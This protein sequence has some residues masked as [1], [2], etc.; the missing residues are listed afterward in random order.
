MI[1]PLIILF[2]GILAAIGY[3]INYAAK[4]Y[5]KQQADRRS[6]TE[7]LGFTCDDAPDRT[8]MDCIMALHRRTPNQALSLKNV[9]MR[10]ESAYTVY[11]LDLIDSSGE[12]TSELMHGGVAIF[13]ESLVIPRFSLM[14]QIPGRGTLT[15]LVNLAMSKLIAGSGQVMRFKDHPAFD[16]RYFF[17]GSDEGALRSFF[18]KP[19]LD[20]LCEKPM[21][22]I[23]GMP[24]AFTY[25]RNTTPAFPPQKPLDQKEILQEA[26][27]LFR[28]F[29]ETGEKTGEAELEQ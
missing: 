12:S 11:I 9:F 29:Q 26:L 10:R 20:V 25:F 2:V 17:V 7:A 3:G 19:L 1:E 21:R 13:S 24:G 4:L 28:M 22:K 14:F 6:T 15:D 18:T 23:E 8:L 5:K 16:E 27:E